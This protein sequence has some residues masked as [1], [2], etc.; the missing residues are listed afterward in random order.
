MPRGWFW[1]AAYGA[2]GAYGPGWGLGWGFRGNP[3]PYCRW[4]P[5]LPRWWWAL[6]GAYRA[7]APWGYPGPYNPDPKAEAEILRQE[8]EALRA[9]LSEIEKR[10]GEMEKGK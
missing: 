1:R 6:P 5:W 4:F 8:A 10:L 7:W 9:E 2:P 3:Y